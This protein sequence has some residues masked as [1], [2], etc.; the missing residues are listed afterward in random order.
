[1]DADPPHIRILQ[2]FCATINQ[3]KGP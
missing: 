2:Y 1:V 3:L